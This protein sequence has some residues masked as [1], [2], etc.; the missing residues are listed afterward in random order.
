MFI[1]IAG[2]HDQSNRRLSCDHDLTWGQGITPGSPGKPEQILGGS[3][4]RDMQQ[5]VDGLA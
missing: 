2:C 4:V 5:V 3:T 1:S